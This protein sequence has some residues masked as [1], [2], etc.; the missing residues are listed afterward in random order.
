M[1]KQTLVSVTAHHCAVTAAQHTPAMLAA[2]TVRMFAMH[3]FACSAC[4]PGTG[5][6]CRIQR[7]FPSRDT[8]HGVKSVMLVM[9]P[10]ASIKNTGRLSESSGSCEKIPRTASRLMSSA[11]AAASKNKTPIPAF[12]R[13]VGLAP[14]LRNSRESSAV[15]ALDVLSVFS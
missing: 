4:C 7:F 2:E 5:M 9:L 12:R 11:T 15:C 3:R 14:S 10:M 13:Y 1:Q 8:E 6:D